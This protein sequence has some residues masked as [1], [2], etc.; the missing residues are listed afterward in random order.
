MCCKVFEQVIVSQVVDYLESNGLLSVNLFNFR[1]RRSV[2]NLLLVTYSGAVEL[3]DRIF[4][5]FP[6]FSKTF[7]VVYFHSVS[8]SNLQML[9]IVGKLLLDSRVFVWSNNVC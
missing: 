8:L 1:R 5:I 4:M 2:E 9:G 3:V 6:A 7:D